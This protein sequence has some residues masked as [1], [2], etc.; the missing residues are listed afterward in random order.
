MPYV[1][2]GF[3]ARDEQQRKCAKLENVCNGV[4]F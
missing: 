4:H 2:V 3:E 1:F